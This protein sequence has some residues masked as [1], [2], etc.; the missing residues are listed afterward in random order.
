MRKPTTTTTKN[1]NTNASWNGQVFVTKNEETRAVRVH[2]ETS[3]V[4]DV[5]FGVYGKNTLRVVS[6]RRATMKVVQSTCVNAHRAKVSIGA[7]F[8]D[9][10]DNGAKRK[11]VA[12]IRRSKQRP[13]R[14]ST[15][16]ARWR[17]RWRRDRR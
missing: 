15:A 16:F 7:F 14:R 2:F 1:N 13:L 17:R 6:K 12:P 9:D 3:V 11:V 4:A 8:F 10:E 5:I